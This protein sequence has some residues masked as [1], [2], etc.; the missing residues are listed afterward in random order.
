MTSFAK[1]A[2][3][4]GL[5]R[6]AGLA[7]SPRGDRLVA[8]VQTLSTKK[9]SYTSALW[10]VDPT[11]T[12]PA[13]RLTHGT[14]GESLAAV[15][16][17]GD[18]LFTAGRPGDDD[19]DGQT[20]TLWTLPAAGGEAR[21]LAKRAGGFAGLKVA[22]KADVLVF[23]S[24]TLPWAPEDA[25]DAKAVKA[26]KESKV[27]AILHQ[28]YPVRFWDHDLGPASTRLF[29]ATA[30]DE[31][32]TARDLSGHLSG[33]LDEHSSWDLS[34]DGSILAISVTVP[35]PGGSLLT[36]VEIWDVATG[37]RRVLVDSPTA[38]HFAPRLSPDGQQV[39]M[40]VETLATPTQAPRQYLAVIPTAGGQVRELTL[41]G[42]LWPGSVRWSADGR[43]LI[44]TCDENGRAPI[45]R[46][47]VETGV[48][49]R[50]TADDGAYSDVWAH[51]DGSCLFALRCTMKSPWQPV[52]IELATGTVT[53]LPSPAPSP[54]VPG[55]LTEVHATADDSRALR[56][57]LMLP[58]GASADTPAPLLL[59]IHGGPLGSWNTWSWRWNPYIMVERG[60]AVLMPDP[61]LSTGYGQQ[62]IDVGWGRWGA[63]PFTDLMTIT[64]ATIARS[65]IDETKT[66]AM[67]G[68][69]G[70]YMANW[71]AG[72]TDRFKAI[73]THAS[74]WALDQFGPTTDAAF[75]WE[76]EMSA[77]MALDNS[78]HRFVSDIVSP[79][80]VIHGDRDYR[81]PIGEGMR[82]WYE[83]VR[84][85]NSTDMPHRFLYFPDE[86]HWILTPNNAQAWYAVVLAFLD[87][88]VH[89]AEW[90]TPAELRGEFDSDD[91][92]QG[93]G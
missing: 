13:R 34:A 4:V 49:H 64:D 69:F 78:P 31:E 66:A 29:A 88:H 59:W 52:R 82:L 87:Q 9:N 17:S 55:T 20:P 54:K 83:L 28:S 32:L 41:N 74:L 39:A 65:D 22:E 2:D 57:W 18:V 61:A 5:P 23:G 1:L 47:C 90:V 63:E 53:E 7:M 43:E 42:G 37:A 76:R 68:S 60:Y 73:V 81:V 46:V 15:T 33:A 86:N 50:I 26:R 92:E 85:A 62:M 58:E 10:A 56:A 3:Y 8:T 27:S 89:G 25:D 44:V 6:I 38:D 93:Q 48:S 12:E 77:Q 21:R 51:P 71:V 67:G 91:D 35:Q 14:K 72:H 19:A 45:Y 16:P 79:M 84:T 36:I 24:A 70:G 40:I 80:L 11:G 30:S 75:Y